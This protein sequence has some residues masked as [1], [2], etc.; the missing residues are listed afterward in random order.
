MKHRAAVLFFLASYLLP[1]VEA[2]YRIVLE[3]GDTI[4]TKE[5]YIKGDSLGF[6]GGKVAKQDVLCLSTGKQTYVFPY[7]SLSLKQIRLEPSE[8]LCE[9]GELYAFKYARADLNTT[10]IND[11]TIDSLGIEQWMACFRSRLM[12]LGIDPDLGSGPIESVSSPVDITSPQMILVLRSG[13][14]LSAPKGYASVNDTIR[15]V[16]GGKVPRSN[17]LMVVDMGG[18]HVFNERTGNKVKLR[19]QVRD[20][21]PGALGVIYAR[22]YWDSVNTTAEIPDLPL[23][24][25]NHALFSEC[26]YI[27]QARAQN[28]KDTIQGI[29][30][31]VSFGLGGVRAFQSAT[32]PIPIR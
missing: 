28:K 1:Q 2:Q 31:L 21:S 13:D 23:A 15:I 20:L 17:V 27:Q 4:R 19:P 26:F 3:R 24:M 9:R 11:P 7:P 12:E 32:S 25:R 18:Q 16:G 29:S 8:R 10:E 14:T 6:P 5:Y 22:I 30:R